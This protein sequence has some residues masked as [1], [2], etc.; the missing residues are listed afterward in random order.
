MMQRTLTFSLLVLAACGN[1]TTYRFVAQGVPADEAAI[2]TT[3]REVEAATGKHLP[4]AIVLDIFAKPFNDTRPGKEGKL[5][6][7]FT[8]GTLIK[9]ALAEWN[10][11]PTQKI[12][13][14]ALAH[15]LLHLLF[16]DPNHTDAAIWHTSALPAC[17]NSIEDKLYKAHNVDMGECLMTVSQYQQATSRSAH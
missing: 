4:A 15:E 17:G 8:E 7:G 1:G 11:T 6:M 5:L 9:L 14:T 12:E 3:M 16:D 10:S 2:E 13:R